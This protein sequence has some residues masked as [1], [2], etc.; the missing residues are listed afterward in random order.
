MR[1]SYRTAAA[2][3]LAAGSAL[4]SMNA[5]ALEFQGVTFTSSVI[6]NMLTIE[7][8]AAGRTGNWASTNYI[9]AIQV[10]DIGHFA[11]GSVA[12]GGLGAGWAAAHAELNG[13][14]TGNACAG[15]P[16][17]WHYCFSG[18]PQALG[19]DMVFTFTAPSDIVGT[20]PHLKVAFYNT[21][22]T[23]GGPDGDLLSQSVPAIPEPG[24]YAML[25][26]GLG[27][28]GCMARRT[29]KL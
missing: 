21:T 13:S 22:T 5:Q 11:F 2:A 28:L 27:L 15:G 24:T 19:D 10:G 20:S 18:T 17:S 4:T 12:I 26:A 8:D 14:P 25:L 3:L 1:I 16:S 23:S 9:G 7:I 6:G 29:R